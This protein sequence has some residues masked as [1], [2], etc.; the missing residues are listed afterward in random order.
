M[1]SD[2]DHVKKDGKRLFLDR[3]NNSNAENMHHIDLSQKLI[4]RNTSDFPDKSNIQYENPS[5]ADFRRNTKNN[6]VHNT[7]LNKQKSNDDHLRKIH[8]NHN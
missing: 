2:L 5:F 3:V 4:A 8:T 7:I 6:F 1:Q